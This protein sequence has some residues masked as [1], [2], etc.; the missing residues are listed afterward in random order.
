MYLSEY[1][2]KAHNNSLETEIN[3]SKTLYSVVGVIDECGEIAGKIKKLHRD[4]GGEISDEWSED[5]SKEIGDVLWYIAEI[6]SIKGWNLSEI[7]EVNC[8]LEGYCNCKDISDALMQ[9][10][11]ATCLLMSG[12]QSSN[13]LE[14]RIAMALLIIYLEKMSNFVGKTLMDIMDINIK[15]VESRRE[16]NVIKGNGDNR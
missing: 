5:I 7:D 15:K 1:Q 4:F 14:T 8:H 16:R 12:V 11:K 6:A 9:S 10:N 3:G 2:A 13:D